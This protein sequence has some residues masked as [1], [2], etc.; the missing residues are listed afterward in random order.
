[1]YCSYNTDPYGSGFLACAFAV[2]YLNNGTEPDY[3]FVPFPTSANDPLITADTVEYYS[4][5]IAWWK[6]IQ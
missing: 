2:Q 3:S 5:N 4:K 6:S 1:M